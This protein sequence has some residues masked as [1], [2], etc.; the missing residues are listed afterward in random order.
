MRREG[1]PWISP[2]FQTCC[3][4]P[5]AVGDEE[6]LNAKET[7]AIHVEQTYTADWGAGPACH[8]RF[9]TDADAKYV[10]AGRKE[11]CTHTGGTRTPK[12]NRQRL[13]SGSQ[14]DSRSKGE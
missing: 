13:Q 2:S 3:D 8:K 6:K 4:E 11:T 10:S 9:R 5:D 12:A 14:Q 7:D 1:L